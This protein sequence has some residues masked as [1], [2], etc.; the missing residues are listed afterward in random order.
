MFV[1]MLH[2][3]III[4]DM[5]FVFV[6]AQ[7]L[8]S[9]PYNCFLLAFWCHIAAILNAVEFNAQQIYQLGLSPI[10]IQCSLFIMLC[11]GS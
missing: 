1:I 8:K 7:P 2:M 11:L 10:E 5:V 3:Y 9:T 6:T 4:C